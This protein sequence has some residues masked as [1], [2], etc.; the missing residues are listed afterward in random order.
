MNQ[1]EPKA[2]GPL[3]EIRREAELKAEVEREIRAQLLQAR[4][5]Q[6]E[7]PAAMLSDVGIRVGTRWLWMTVVIGG[8]VWMFG[9]FNRA[10]SN[11]A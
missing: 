11:T 10:R 3:A 4:E 7:R 2:T 6:R 1:P 5:F 8:L 9:G